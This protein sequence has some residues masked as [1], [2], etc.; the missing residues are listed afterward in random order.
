MEQDDNDDDDDD[1]VSPYFLSMF[2]ILTCV[3]SDSFFWR[4]SVFCWVDIDLFCCNP[5]FIGYIIIILILSFS[6]LL[7][8]I[9]KT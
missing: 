3:S 5:L 9:L 4:S 8:L 7:H 6:L 2:L 1:V